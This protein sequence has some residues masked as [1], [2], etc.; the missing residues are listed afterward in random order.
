[1]AV[2]NEKFK[3]LSDLIRGLRQARTFTDRP[4]D[5]D[6][7]LSIVEAA[8]LAPSAN[9]SQ[10]WRFHVYADPNVVPQGERLGGGVLIAA[11]AEEA[12]L[13][14]RWREQPFIMID[15]PIALTHMILHAQSLG[16]GFRLVFDFEKE[17]LAGLTDIPKGH[18][19]V[20]LLFIGRPESFEETAVAPAEDVV[21][22]DRF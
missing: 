22:V 15:V 11:C 10:P 21:I 9:N 2:E 12:I 19:P 16:L 14:N 20:A 7:I 3:H 4:V 18:K 1:M 8:R 5:R 6:T 13:S 17:D